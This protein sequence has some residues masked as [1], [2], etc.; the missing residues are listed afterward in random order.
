MPG[1]WKLFNK[2]SL[3]YFILQVTSNPLFVYIQA[4]RRQVRFLEN[5]Q[6]LSQSLA[7]IAWG[8]S[9]LIISYMYIFLSVFDS[10]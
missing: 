5:F 7:V 8:V 4:I 10:S 2:T 6:F 1:I 9:M 3:W